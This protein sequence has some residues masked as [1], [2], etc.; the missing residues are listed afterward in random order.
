MS[1]TH[2]FV[3]VSVERLCI[4]MPQIELQNAPERV[5]RTGKKYISNHQQKDKKKAI[6]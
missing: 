3:T 1:K 5:I 4:L 6:Q 2:D